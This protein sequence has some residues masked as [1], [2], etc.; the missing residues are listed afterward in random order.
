ME[1][2]K[3]SGKSAIYSLLIQKKTEL[4]R[5]GVLLVAGE[6]VRG[7]PVFK[8]LEADP[9]ASEEQFRALWKLYLLSLIGSTLKLAEINSD[10]A[11]RVIRILSESGLIE[12]DLGL[13][14]IL[15]GALE[16]ARRL[17]LEG[18]VK[19]GEMSGAPEGFSARV[20]LQEPSAHDRSL[21]FVSADELLAEANDAFGSMG[22]KMW[23]LLD[24]LD[25]AFADSP[26]LEANALRALFRVYLDLQAHDRLSVKIF[27]RDDIWNRITAAGF[28]EASHIT[29]SIR[30]TW[31][32][33]TLLNLIIRRAIYN[34]SIQQYYGLLPDEV[35]QSSE[36][37]LSLFYKMFPAQVDPGGGKTVTLNW[38]LSHSA[39]GT[40]QTAPRELIHLLSATRDAQLR[41]LEIGTQEPPDTI[42]LDRAALKEGIKEVSETR[43]HQTIYAEYPTLKHW[44]SRLHGE[45][46]QQTAE[47]LAIVW[48]INADEALKIA[49]QLVDVGF[50]EKRGSKHEP[51]FWAPFLYRDALDLVQGSAIK[52]KK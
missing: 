24:R 39:D 47:T 30:I 31:D 37:Q 2:P 5:R 17:D 40:K 4:N 11:K 15:R 36:K 33:K 42:L 16:Y 26:E 10:S 1:G 38:M 41:L 14:R 22:W 52:K 50:F 8:D 13:R 46:T 29:K 27:L 18:T 9:P 48:R 12:E 21:G 51:S 3:G 6:N 45:K 34:S 32:T 35:L 19:V 43:L 20:R 44:I 25:V 28:R 49:N 23:I 7:T